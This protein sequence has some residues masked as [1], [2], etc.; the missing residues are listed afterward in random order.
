MAVLHQCNPPIHGYSVKWGECFIRFIIDYGVDTNPV[1]VIDVFED[2][3]CISIDSNEFYFG[4]N[5]MY[6]LQKPDVPKERQI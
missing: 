2:R 6:D 1:F 3:R 5:G 4:E